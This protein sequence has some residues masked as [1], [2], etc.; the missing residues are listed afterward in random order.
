MHKRNTG[1]ILLALLVATGLASQ[2][3]NPTI[4]QKERS[5]LHSDL[6][7]TKKHLLE[8]VNH[9]SE[10]QLNFHPAAGSW[11]VADCIRHIALAEENIWQIAEAGIKQPAAPEKRV[12]IKVTD[13]QLVTMV[14]DRSK[15]AQ[16]P[17]VLQ[18]ASAK[19]KSTGDALGAFKGSR[20]RL[21]KYV[22]TT[23]QDL[24]NHVIEDVTGTLDAYQ[25][26]LLISAHTDRH[27]QQI[28]E[29]MSNPKF[30]K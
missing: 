24:R 10:E 30:P 12:N 19:W 5:F 15:K 22:K 27:T 2:V 25:M 13:E 18:P 17:E 11:S 8:A 1:Y 21:M 28:R 14:K 4:T 9:L 20:A 7:S 23:T 29:I 16:A 6:K 3:Y 26:L